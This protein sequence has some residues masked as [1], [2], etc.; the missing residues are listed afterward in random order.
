[1]LTN[2]DYAKAFH[3]IKNSITIINS[4]LQLLEKQHPELST[5]EYWTESRDTLDYLKQMVQELSQANL[6]SDFVLQPTNLNHLLSGILAS[7]RSLNEN[8]GCKCKS[9]IEENLPMIAADSMRLNQAIMNLIKNAF[10]AMDMQ[11]TILLNAYQKNHSIFIDIVDFGGGISSDLTETLFSPFVTSK[12]GGTGLGL[13]ISQQI[14]ENHHGTL[15]Y[16][17]RPGDGCTFTI[18]LPVLNS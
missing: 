13:S 10:E 5:Y 7:I 18:T 14:I 15:N 4:S 16:V 17:S 3:E 9:N 8:N 2:A 6:S 11:G 12:P 1:M